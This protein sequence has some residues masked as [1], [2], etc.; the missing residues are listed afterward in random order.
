MDHLFSMLAAL[1]SLWKNTSVSGPI[2][3][4]SEL[5]DRV[6]AW[7]FW[8]SSSAYFNVQPCLGTRDTV[9]MEGR[10]CHHSLV[11]AMG[12]WLVYPWWL[13]LLRMWAIWSHYCF[14]LCNHSWNFHP[15]LNFAVIF[16]SLPDFLVLMSTPPSVKRRYTELPVAFYW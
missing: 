15:T 1:R 2:H 9:R 4:D 8:K 13:H 6:Q 16:V 11:N 5:I 10:W 7:V 12:M 3:R 14:L